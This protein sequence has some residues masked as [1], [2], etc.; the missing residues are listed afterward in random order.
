MRQLVPHAIDSLAAEDTDSRVFRAEML[1]RLRR[2][3]QF[4]WYAW[5]LTDPSTT[6]G[7]D[8]LAHV[9]DLADLPRVV[10]LK[11]LTRANRWSSLDVAATLGGHAV[12]SPLWR[13]VQRAHGV[14]DVASVVFRDRFGCWG[15]LDLWSKREY[16]AEDV[17]LLR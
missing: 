4:D 3:I 2:V 17:A 14:V 10:R 8:P 11:Y 1:E 7:V 12:D 13:E 16:A 5:V 6:V 15:F 9:P